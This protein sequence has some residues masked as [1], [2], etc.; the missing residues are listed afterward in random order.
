MRTKLRYLLIAVSTIT[1]LSVISC[2][3]YDCDWK[4]LEPHSKLTRPPG[5]GPFPAM[6]LLHG[7]GGMTKPNLRTQAWTRR[8][9]QWG[10][11]TLQVDSFTPRNISGICGGGMPSMELLRYRASDAR[12]AKAY[13]ER[14]DFVD[15]EK[16]GVMGWSHGGT[17]VIDTVLTHN[18]KIAKRPFKAAV[19]F[20]PACFKPLEPVSPLLILSGD[21][22]RWTPANLCRRHMP[23]DNTMKRVTL[24]IYPGAY[25]SFDWTGIDTV[26]EGHILRYHPKAATDA[27][28]KVKAFLQLNLSGR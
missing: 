4:R 9:T 14:L 7:C 10:Y 12:L 13:L 8:L 3:N 28:G 20:Y 26:L 17:T 11:V 25:H 18:E 16:I 23:V 5:Q 1:L 15:P 19:A 22:D 24:K 2:Q 21:K 6:V 27:I